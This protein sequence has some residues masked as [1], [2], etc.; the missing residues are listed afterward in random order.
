[1]KVVKK[2]NM[3]K[4]KQLTLVVCAFIL[5]GVGF[6]NYTPSTQDSQS[7]AVTKVE[8]SNNIGD[9]QL[10]SSNA[11]V[12]NE[13][14]AVSAIVENEN[15]SKNEVE[16]KVKNEEALKEEDY[17][18]KTKLERDTMYS[19]ML[20]S[21]KN[22]INNEKLAE[23]QKSIAVQEIDKINQAQNS[24]MIAENLIINKGF[25]NAVVLVNNN[26]V[27]VVVKATLLKDEDI[28]KIQNIIEREFK[29]DISQINISN[30]N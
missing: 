7:V 12:E 20:D 30:K 27:N 6:M 19:K 3:D 13:N 14:T 21:Y 4:I 23:T 11:I 8:N 1:M 9:V 17:F 16:N 28:V 24:I 2:L 5:L 29:V 15:E 22:I 18:A 26:A 25:E 10:V